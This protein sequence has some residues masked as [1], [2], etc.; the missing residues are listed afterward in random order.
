MPNLA[1][2]E[3]NASYLQVRSVLQRE[4]VIS[5]RNITLRGLQAA[6]VV[7]AGFTPFSGNA[8]RRGRVGIWASLVGYVVRG[9]YVGLIPDS[10]LPHAPYSDVASRPTCN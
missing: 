4:Q 5:G 2:R 8:G 6:G 3:S 10:L 7:I 1:Y 9:A